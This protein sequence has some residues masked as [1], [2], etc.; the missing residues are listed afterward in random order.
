MVHIAKQVGISLILVV[1][2]MITSTVIDSHI[3][4]TQVLFLMMAMLTMMT[5]PQAII[6]ESL[7][8][9]GQIAY[10]LQMRT[11]NVA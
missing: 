9:L 11:S 2:E 1:P 7:H 4:T 5:L 8:N 3:I 6:S 10:P